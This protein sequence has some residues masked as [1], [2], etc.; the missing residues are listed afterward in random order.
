MTLAPSSAVPEAVIAAVAAVVPPP[1]PDAGPSG[2]EAL[3]PQEGDS[4]TFNLKVSDVE[5][6][7]HQPLDLLGV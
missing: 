5:Q 6:R 3:D 2:A 7:K 4:V 1:L